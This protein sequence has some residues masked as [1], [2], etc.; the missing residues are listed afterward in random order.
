LYDQI[1]IGSVSSSVTGTDAMALDVVEYA[2]SAVV[3]AA[4]VVE[5]ALVVSCAVVIGVVS[6]LLSINSCIS[7]SFSST[8]EKMPVFSEPTSSMTSSS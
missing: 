6:V 4:V 7:K 5:I 8:F 1:V 2:D 3:A